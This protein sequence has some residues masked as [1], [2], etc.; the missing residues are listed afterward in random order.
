MAALRLIFCACISMVLAL[1][2]APT[3]VKSLTLAVS[4]PPTFTSLPRWRMCSLVELPPLYCPL[5]WSRV[6]TVLSSQSPPVLTCKSC[7]TLRPAP[8]MIKSRSVLITALL[9][10]LMLAS[11]PSTVCV[12][13]TAPLSLLSC[14]LS[15]RRMISRP[16]SSCR[17]VAFNR[18][19]VRSISLFS[20]LSCILLPACSKPP[21]LFRAMSCAI[22]RFRLWVAFSAPELVKPCI[23]VKAIFSAEINAPLACRSPDFTPAR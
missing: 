16:L 10:T 15:V 6:W 11:G 2:L 19:P 14:A 12:R 9:L 7:P 17:L 18:L 3:A 13:W 22:L 20:V 23:S 1:M 21:R 5:I 4:A 8:C